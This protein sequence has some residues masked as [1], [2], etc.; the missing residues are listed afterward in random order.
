VLS[1]LKEWK[2][3]FKE[4][5]GGKAVNSW[6][7]CFRSSE[8]HYIHPVMACGDFI[9]TTS[10]RAMAS[11]TI[12]GGRATLEY[13]KAHPK[14][15]G[16]VHMVSVKTWGAHWVT[17]VNST[18]VQDEGLRIGGIGHQ[19]NSKVNVSQTRRVLRINVTVNLA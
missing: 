4:L 17:R 10:W 3:S 12:H 14:E 15:A 9:W 6:T 16:A 5:E 1:F 2:V 11:S 7:A 19:M 8:N 18:N 13:I